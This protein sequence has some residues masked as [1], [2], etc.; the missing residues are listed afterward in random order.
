ME[1]FFSFVIL[2]ILLFILFVT[3]LKFKNKLS[4]LEHKVELTMKETLELATADQL[5]KEIRKRK[6]TPFVMLT[7]IKEKDY[8][9]LTIESH[10]V[11]SASCLAILHLARSITMQAFK[12][13][14]EDVPNLPSVDDYFD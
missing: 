10:S 4:E 7:P 12:K 5:L 11:N 8:N 1:I 3:I 9:G 6:G 14:G 2:S 13:R